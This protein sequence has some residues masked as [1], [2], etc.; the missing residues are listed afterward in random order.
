ML[1]LTPYPELHELSELSELR[2]W[3]ETRLDRRW[4]AALPRQAEG[5][6]GEADKSCVGDGQG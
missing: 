5:A 4:L 6:L 1:T 2:R 3:H